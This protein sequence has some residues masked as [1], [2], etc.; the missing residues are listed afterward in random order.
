MRNRRPSVG[1]VESP[2]VKICF[3]ENGFC[4]GCLRSMTEIRQW[5]IMSQE[6]QEHLLEQL[7]RRSNV[8]NTRDY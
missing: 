2:C 7:E 4:I 5:P 8:R 6:A 3:I 1:K